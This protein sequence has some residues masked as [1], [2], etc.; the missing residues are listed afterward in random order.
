MTTREIREAFLSYFERRGHLRIPS[1]LLVPYE[2]DPSV[3]LTIAGMQPLKAYF[4]GAGTP[5][6]QRMTSCS[7]VLP[8]G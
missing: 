3:L 1:A 4:L 7:E 6:A 2:D 5:P 8:H